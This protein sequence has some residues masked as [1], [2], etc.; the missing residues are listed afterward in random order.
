MSFLAGDADGGASIIIGQI[1]IRVVVEEHLDDVC[2]SIQNG[3]QE[4]WAA[5]D[6]LIDI[7]PAVE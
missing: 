2:V 7:N 4:G 1:D 6:G 5:V 3:D